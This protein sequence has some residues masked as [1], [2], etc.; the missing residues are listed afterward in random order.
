[1]AD[2][3]QVPG[4]I[5]SDFGYFCWGLFVFLTRRISD[6]HLFFFFFSCLWKDANINFNQRRKSQLRVYIRYRFWAMEAHYCQKRV[7]MKTI[8]EILTQNVLFQ[9]KKT[10]LQ[11]QN[12]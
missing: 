6:V 4:N 11:S 10:L 7:L 12:N 2:E 9:N 5:L 1:M 3:K 8:S